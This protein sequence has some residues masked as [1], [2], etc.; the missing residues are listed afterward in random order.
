MT[1]G[2]KMTPEKPQPPRN[3]RVI[4]MGLLGEVYIPQDYTDEQAEAMLK[5]YQW[6]FGMIIGLF[7]LVLSIIILGVAM[8]KDAIE[9]SIGSDG[10]PQ[11][12]DQGYN[13]L[14][15]RIE[16][17]MVEINKITASSEWQT[18]WANHLKT[19]KQCQDGQEVNCKEYQNSVPKLINGEKL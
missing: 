7:L 2:E 19:C 12:T 4:D 10:E 3:Q 16:K 14:E 1:T 11:I 6:I 15:E 13:N 5:R 8:S 18:W 17:A 9:T